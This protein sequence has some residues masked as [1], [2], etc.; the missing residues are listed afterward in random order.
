MDWQSA[1]TIGLLC[2][3]AV[4]LYYAMK[5]LERIRK[6]VEIVAEQTKRPQYE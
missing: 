3:I 1:V 5:E 6:A 2:S 4:M